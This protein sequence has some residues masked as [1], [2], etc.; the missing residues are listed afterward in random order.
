MWRTLQKR[1]GTDSDFPERVARLSA[2]ERVLDGTMYDVL[3]FAMHEEKSD[4]GEY[5][6][7]R[8]R[9]P[10]VRHNLCKLAVR[11][12]SAML[13]SNA[14]FP[15]I[16]HPD[17]QTQEALRQLAQDV[18]LGLTMA[19]AAHVGSVGSVCLWLRILAGRVY[20]DVLPTKYLTPEYDAQQP[21]RLVSVTERR[22]LKG[23]QLQA[24]GYVIPATDL[25]AMH[26]WQRVWNESAEEWYAP[27]KL[28]QADKPP[29]L[30]KGKTIQHG[31]GFVP[32][33]WIRNLPSQDPIDG[34][35]TF[36]DESIETQIELE[37]LLSQAGRAL[38]YASDP[39]LLIK[40]PAVDADG[41]FVRSASNAMVVGKDGDAK[42]VEINGTATDAVLGYTQV[43]VRTAREQLQL[44]NIDPDKLSA[45]QSGRALELLMDSL[46]QLCDQLRTTYGTEGL[47]R[48]LQM[49]VSVGSRSQLMK[50]DD[51]TS[52]GELKKGQVTLVWP[53]WFAPTSQELGD[54]AGTLRTNTDASHLSNETAAR[55]VAEL[56]D[57]ED[58]EA[59][60]ARI[61]ADEAERAAQ[62]PQIQEKIVA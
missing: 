56:Y 40:E 6:K 32:L 11:K 51:E 13:F 60:L 24:M 37:Y 31:L 27:Q 35:P 20:V 9:R 50:K 10:S 58:V 22:K 59:E 12:S 21:D 29:K 3:R 7:L 34:A 48:L 57:I 54:I 4:G 28:D 1:Y 15:Q 23:S 62:A 26:W 8:D 5:I 30:D 33:V 53:R 17:E 49:I 16:V 43:L 41:S 14:H 19:Q 38:K 18:G 55:I 44:P 2:L 42:L 47:Q 25:G 46:I 45:A 36:D 39:M 61:K 52:Y